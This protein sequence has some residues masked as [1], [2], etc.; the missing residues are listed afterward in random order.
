MTRGE[1]TMKYKIHPVVEVTR[2]LEGRNPS[3]IFK[4]SG[5]SMR[6]EW[7]HWLVA[8]PVFILAVF[9]VLLF[10]TVAIGWATAG[11]AVGYVYHD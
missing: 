6:I 1:L 5:Q 8:I 7:W 4:D 11:A 3:S 9:V 10:A 2:E